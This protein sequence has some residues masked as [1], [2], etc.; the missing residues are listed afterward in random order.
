MLRAIAHASFR[1]HAVDLACAGCIEHLAFATVR[2]YDGN[3]DYPTC[4]EALGPNDA[5]DV[6]DAAQAEG[7]RT[8][9]SLCETL[10]TEGAPEPDRWEVEE[11]VGI[12]WA[13]QLL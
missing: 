2:G 6:L 1:D 13:G 5:F 12:Y 3:A 8:C 7:R 10:A 4:S 11:P 9:A